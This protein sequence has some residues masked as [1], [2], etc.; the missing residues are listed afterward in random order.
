MHDNELGLH[1]P[2]ETVLLIV[3]CLDFHFD[4]LRYHGGPS[5]L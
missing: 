4:A 1:G 5:P 2:C 3:V